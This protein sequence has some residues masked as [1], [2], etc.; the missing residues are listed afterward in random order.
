MYEHTFLDTQRVVHIPLYGKQ[1][2]WLCCFQ[3]Q[4][5][6]TLRLCRSNS[7]L[8]T[9]GVVYFACLSEQSYLSPRALLPACWEWIHL[10]TFDCADLELLIISLG[11]CTQLYSGLLSLLIS[12][13][14][15][16]LLFVNS[17]RATATMMMMIMK[18]QMSCL[19]AASAQRM[20]W[21]AALTARWICTVQDVSGMRYVRWLW[22][23][24]T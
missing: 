14:E 8:N 17:P 21:F 19:T 12:S 3:K 6:S 18:T 9:H 13:L 20:Q 16:C 23:H 22:Y 10:C 2:M 24:V 7:V 4:H 5:E 11:F 1:S 15:T